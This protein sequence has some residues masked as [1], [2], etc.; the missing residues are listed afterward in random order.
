MHPLVEQLPHLDARGDGI[1]ERLVFEIVPDHL[2][3]LQRM[4]GSVVWDDRAYEGVPVIGCKRPY[5][6]SAIIDDIHEIV[7]G[8]GPWTDEGERAYDSYAETYYKAL[9]REMEFV[10]S[11]VLTTM[12]YAPGKYISTTWLGDWRRV[13]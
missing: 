12:S 10:L 4:G 6:N 9:H 2:K 7:T 13:D 3:L 1:N 5:G 11:I 8:T